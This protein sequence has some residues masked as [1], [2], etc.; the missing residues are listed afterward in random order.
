MTGSTGQ[1]DKKQVL[2]VAVSLG[3][4]GVQPL[5]PTKKDILQIKFKTR[6]RLDLQEQHAKPFFFTLKTCPGVQSH[7]HTL[8]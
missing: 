5:R 1:T 6:S 8:C 7:S 2:Q 4:A 3:P